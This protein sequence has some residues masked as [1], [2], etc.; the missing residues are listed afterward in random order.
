MARIST[1]TDPGTGDKS[2]LLRPESDR[3]VVVYYEN[4]PFD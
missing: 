2:P 4:L 1:G 3:S